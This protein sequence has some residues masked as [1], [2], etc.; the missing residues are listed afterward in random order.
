ME[1]WIERIGHPQTLTPG[2]RQD[3]EQLA[4]RYPWLVPAQQLLLRL[5][6]GCGDETEALRIRDQLALRLAF[7]PAPELLLQEPDWSSLQR[8]GS[9]AMV[10]DFLAVADKRIVPENSAGGETAD[11]A[12]GVPGPEQDDLVSEPLAKIYAAQGLH[13]QAVAIYRRLSLKFPEKSAYFADCISE[14]KQNK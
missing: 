14:L 6:E 11:L 1:K 3:L 7:Y 4:G 9:M 2:D 5:A 8:R 12:Q 13:E 10:E